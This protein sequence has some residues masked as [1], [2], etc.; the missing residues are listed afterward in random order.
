MRLLIRVVSQARA[1]LKRISV[2]H[3]LRDLSQRHILII[4]TVFSLVFV[5]MIKGHAPR[6]DAETTATTNLQTVSTV[7]T[8]FT[9]TSVT[10]T[11]RTQ[12]LTSMTVQTIYTTVTST[13]SITSTTTISSC[14]ST[15]SK[16]STVYLISSTIETFRSSVSATITKFSPTVTLTVVRTDTV[17]L[18]IVVTVSLLVTNPAA[19]AA[20]SLLGVVCFPLLMALELKRKRRREPSDHETLG[21]VKCLSE[22]ERRR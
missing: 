6:L 18:V 11:S 4:I 2:H 17:T 5:A 3:Y 13:Q 7:I 20:T 10:Y 9:D 1:R 12:T 15:E 16:I 19:G 14:V 8:S 21:A 22:T